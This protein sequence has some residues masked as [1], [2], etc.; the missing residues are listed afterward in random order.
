MA[1]TVGRS[2]AV[3]RDCT[4]VG[5]R[6]RRAAARAG[7]ACR[8]NGLTRPVCAGGAMVIMLLSAAVADAAT[9]VNRAAK[10]D[11]AAATHE[12]DVRAAREQLE[13]ERS[14]AR[15]RDRELE[16]KRS[17]AREV[18]PVAKS[19]VRTEELEVEPGRHAMA[20][21]RNIQLHPGEH[22]RPEH[23]THTQVRAHAAP[24]NS[25]PKW[26]PTPALAPARRPRTEWYKRP[27]VVLGPRTRTRTPSRVR[28]TTYILACRE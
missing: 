8:R 19:V 25:G 2:V 12:R 6:R 23:A 10:A 21:Y 24:A 9:A 14:R 17:R 16:S 18:F 1:G 7:A 22:A 20:L 26:S 4:I 5:P 27:V 28:K 11:A 13:S 15:E 3:A